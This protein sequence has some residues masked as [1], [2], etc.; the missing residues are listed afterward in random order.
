MGSHEVGSLAMNL[1]NTML[2][3]MSLN[4]IN[5]M[6]ADINPGAMDFV[7]HSVSVY[8]E[9]IRPFIP[10]CS[11]YHFNPE[12][13]E[14]YRQ[15]WCAEEI[16]SEDRGRAAMTVSALT[17]S[18]Q[19]RLLIYPKGLD[20]GAS[21]RVTLDNTGDAFI[22]TGNEIENSGLRLTIPASLMSELVLF[23]RV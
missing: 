1:R 11:V 16:V 5:P 8:K 7:K 18:K 9:F 4:V 22:M 3:H 10:A 12:W 20:R 2:G 17:V 6:S 19:D 21:Y 23:E 13:K 15:G 14:A